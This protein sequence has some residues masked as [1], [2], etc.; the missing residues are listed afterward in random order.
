[1]RDGST[2]ESSVS[3]ANLYGVYV[4]GRGALI[5]DNVIQA[6]S[7]NAIYSSTTP[8]DVAYGGNVL[9]GNNGTNTIIDGDQG[10]SGTPIGS[11]FCGTDTT[12]P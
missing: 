10:I 8:S 1:M 11:N 5:R 9:V 7:S 3:N 6:N 12:C 4:Q 2:V